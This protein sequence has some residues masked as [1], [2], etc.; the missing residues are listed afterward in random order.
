MQIVIVVILLIVI[1]ILIA[2]NVHIQK[3]IEA[4]NNINQQINK[5]SVLQEFMKVAGEEDSVDAKLNKINEIVIEQYD[6]K[7]STIV[8]FNGAPSG[9]S[10]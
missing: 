4:F 10:P 3:K 5:L 8:V 9:K 6:I 1:G 7:Y 2:Y